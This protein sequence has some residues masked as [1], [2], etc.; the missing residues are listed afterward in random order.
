VSAF[1]SSGSAIPLNV[2]SSYFLS[3]LK[4]TSSTVDAAVFLSNGG[5]AWSSSPA[6]A[7]FSPMH[8]PS[9]L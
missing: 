3:N 7:A 4:P 1:L 2:P 8:L 6:V 5:D 9:L